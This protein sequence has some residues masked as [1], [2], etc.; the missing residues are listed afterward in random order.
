MN[1]AV[2][3]VGIELSMTL[4]SLSVVAIFLYVWFSAN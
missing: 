3:S 1:R 2:A 4:F